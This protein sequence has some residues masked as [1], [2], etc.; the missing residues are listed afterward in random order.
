MFRTIKAVLV[1]IAVV[2]GLASVSMTFRYGLIFTDGPERIMFAVLFGASDAAKFF[3]LAWGGHLLDMGRRGLAY[4]VGLVW[5]FLVVVSASFHVGL[6]MTS[7]DHSAGD[8]LGAKARYDQAMSDRDRFKAQLAAMGNPREVAV[9]ER[10]IAA[11][12]L[13][14]KW[15][16]S[17][18]CGD[19]TLDDSR[20]FC[21]EIEKLEGEKAVAG[22]AKALRAKLDDASLKVSTLTAG[23]VFQRADAASEQMGAALALPKEQVLFI[24]ALL[25][26]AIIETCSSIL[27]HV[28]LAK[29]LQPKVARQEVAPAEVAPSPEAPS[30]PEPV[31]EEKPAAPV[32]EEEAP[33]E[34]VPE[35]QIDA[36]DERP[37]LDVCGWA[38]PRLRQQI[39]G[40]VDYEQF[41]GAYQQD[42]KSLDMRTMDKNGFSRGIAKAGFELGGKAGRD[43]YIKDAAIKAAKLALVEG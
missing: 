16:R 14:V 26:A 25:V 31:A 5:I 2:V 40:K 34:P 30:E 28:A 8:T 27:L 38:K 36:T 41:F 39:G 4:S 7:K 15:T 33:V 35:I 18:Q 42:G 22:D 13:D 43:R 10:E 24:V 6:V 32:V 29:P 17:K 21:Q 23:A 12:K 20:S 9:I 19:A 37:V 11:K 1:L 3:M